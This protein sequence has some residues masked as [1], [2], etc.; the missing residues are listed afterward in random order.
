MRLPLDNFNPPTDEGAFG[1]IR[2]HDIHTGVDLYCRAGTKV[3]AMENGEVVNIDFFT[4]PIAGSPWW[5]DTFAVLIEGKHGVICYGEI[6]PVDGLSVGHKIKEGDLIGRV[7]QVLK[8]NKRKPMSML[9]L[10]LYKHGTRETVWWKHG[11]AKP[12]QLLNPQFDLFLSDD[13]FK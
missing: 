13:L 11:E 5:N 9:H 6:A 2:K 7:A 10:E 3:Y 4:G 12:D 1:A 8:K